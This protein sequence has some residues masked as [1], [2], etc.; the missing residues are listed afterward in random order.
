MSPVMACPA[1]LLL[2]TDE[3]TFSRGSLTSLWLHVAIAITSEP[4][5]YSG[6]EKSKHWHFL[7]IFRHIV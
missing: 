5:L 1:G 2:K 3:V 6:V 7:K 4:S